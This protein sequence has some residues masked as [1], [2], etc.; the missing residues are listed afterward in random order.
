MP[1][2][3]RMTDLFGAHVVSG[4]P[5]TMHDIR[6]ALLAAV[7]E[8]EPDDDHARRCAGALA[9]LVGPFHAPLPKLIPWLEGRGWTIVEQG[10]W[11]VATRGQGRDPKRWATRGERS[12]RCEVELPSQRAI[13][14]TAHARTMWFSV[15]PD[16]AH[17]EDVSP[18]TLRCLLWAH[19]EGL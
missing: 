11:R 3:H 6:R 9:A 18:D 7:R 8:G 2:W 12:E 10:A 14:P 1:D 13:D 19:V 5:G 16:L 17:A 4:D 15:L